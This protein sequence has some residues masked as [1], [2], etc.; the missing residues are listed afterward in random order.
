MLVNMRLHSGDRGHT[1]PGDPAA[2][3]PRDAA[4]TRDHLLRAAMR[5]FTVYGYDRSTTRDI[6]AAAGVNVSL[7]ARY[8]G[9]KDGLYAA[10]LEASAGSFG[11]HG[12]GDLVQ[13]VIDG[14][15]ADA[16]P[17]FGGQHPLL[18]LLRDDSDDARTAE[19]RRRTLTSAIGRLTE[20][21]LPGS[22]VTDPEARLRGATVLALVAG[23][24]A[25]RSAVPDD[26]FGAVAVDS[27][28]RVLAA[29]V[30]AV[31]DA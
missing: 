6:A 16:W 15:Q 3:R 28:R 19:L 27:L 18:L 22:S 31:A 2:P 20:Q 17:E 14:L 1:A 29:A 26:P 12:S 10:V 5:R 30:T 25:L 7:I 24:T 4:A 9:S 23:V 11:S 21:V 8:F 13:D